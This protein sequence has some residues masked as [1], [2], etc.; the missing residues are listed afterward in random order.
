MSKAIEMSPEE[1]R[2]TLRQ[3]ILVSGSVT[4]LGGY[5]D[6]VKRT[7]LCAFNIPLEPL[8]MVWKGLSIIGDLP[9]DLRENP[10]AKVSC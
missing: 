7:G 2:P 5:M 4:E 8:M 9:K 1:H 3:S 6:S 10:Q